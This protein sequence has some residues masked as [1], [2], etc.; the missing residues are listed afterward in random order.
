MADPTVIC[1]LG[2]R[3]G[4]SLVARVLNLLGVD[5]GPA[6]AMMPANANNRRGFWEHQGIVEVNDAVLARHSATWPALPTLAAGW[7][8]DPALAELY[9]R[10]KAIV[11]R[12]FAGKALWGWKDPRA[13][14]T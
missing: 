13:C 2:G 9:D 10:A 1:I 6:D 3:S 11:A 5:L 4:T 12:D 8:N 7:E 14:V